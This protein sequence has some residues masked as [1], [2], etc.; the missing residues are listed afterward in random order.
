MKTVESFLKDRMEQSSFMA[1][2]IPRWISTPNAF[3]GKNSHTLQDAEN[4]QKDAAKCKATL[5]FLAEYNRQE[6]AT[7]KAKIRA[8]ITSN[9][10]L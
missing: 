1:M 5:K 10:N 6:R 3:V 2:M 4:F 8:E 9:P 7:L